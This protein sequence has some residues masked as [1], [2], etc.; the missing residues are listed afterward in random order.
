MPSSNETA[1]LVLREGE[2]MAVDRLCVGDG[3]T[4]KALAEE[5]TKVS[6][7]RVLLDL[8]HGS[9]A[10]PLPS[11]PEED[12]DDD[13]GEFRP[14]VTWARYPSLIQVGNL[15]GS[16]NLPSGRQV[17][18]L[19]KVAPASDQQARA[20]LRR[21]WSY[22]MDLALREDNAAAGMEAERDLPLHEWLLQ[23]FVQQ[24]DRLIAKGLRSHY[25]EEEDNLLTLRGR[26]MVGENIRR[27][28]FAANRFVCRFDSFSLNR[29]ENRLIRSA[30]DVVV[31]ITTQHDTRKRA[32]ALRELMHEIPASGHIHA[33]FA[34][35]RSDRSMANYREIRQTCEWLLFRRAAV[36][37]RGSHE[38]WGRL[39]RMNDVFERYVTRWLAEKCDP[40][41]QLSGQAHPDGDG[42]RVLAL[43]GNR[44]LHSMRPD[45]VIRQGNR[46][47]AVLDVKWK[48]SKGNKPVSREDLYQLFAYA[49]HWLAD[50]TAAQPAIDQPLRPKLIAAVYPA[51]LTEELEKGVTSQEFYFNKIENLRGFRL[52]FCV[53]TQNGGNWVEGFITDEAKN[54]FFDYIG[55]AK[56][57]MKLGNSNNRLLPLG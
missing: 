45:I 16:F 53:P 29:P 10:A 55:L 47:V 57:T 24:L 5:L 21:M 15:V 22:A 28:A 37:V 44:A 54:S 26:L 52:H 27:N 43:Q 46:N 7:Q 1:P 12:A 20:S 8:A 41:F 32:A 31:R 50:T 11:D 56:A 48:I 38:A 39:V 17:E 49:S 42:E 6:V 51:V 13:V 18:I 14:V 25:V 4:A 9:R 35:W 2:T 19:P 33:D 40:A 23:R 36:P 34:A 30:L 3:Q